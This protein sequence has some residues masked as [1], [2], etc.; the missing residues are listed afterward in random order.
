MMLLQSIK[1]NGE[2]EQISVPRAEYCQHDMRPLVHVPSNS[3]VDSKLG[4]RKRRDYATRHA[5]YRWR[6]YVRWFGSVIFWIE[7]WH[8][9]YSGTLTL[10]SVVTPFVFELEAC[11]AEQ[12]D[13]GLLKPIKTQNL[14]EEC[15]C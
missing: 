11:T 6:F 14:A 10:I 15:S 3:G 1:A 7:N 2:E 4:H 13:I 5:S 12:T 8:I 9:D